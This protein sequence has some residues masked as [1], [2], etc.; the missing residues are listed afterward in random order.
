MELRAAI[1]STLAYFDLFDY[2]PTRAEVWRWLFAP[3]P[4]YKIQDTK[5]TIA[6][7]DSSIT[8]LVSAGT[9]KEE[10]GFVYLADR[11]GLPA[12]REERYRHS[13]RK[14]RRARRWARV[15]GA[16]PGVELVGIGNTLAFHAAKDASDIDFFIVTKPGTIW[17]TRALCAG[18]AALFRLRPTE[19]VTRDKLCLSFF[20]TD[21]A[22]DLAPLKHPGAELDIYLLYWIAQMTPL[23]G[24]SHAYDKFFE[25][26]AWVWK[27]LPNTAVRFVTYETNMTGRVL[28][29]LGRVLGFVSGDFMKEKQML[30]FPPAINEAVARRDGSAV[31]SDSM[32]K[33]HLNDRRAQIFE[34]WQQRLST[35]L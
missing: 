35:L 5:Y 16:L 26:N 29:V 9:L 34:R 19:T 32:L 31:I 18:L 21:D 22:L 4:K 23:A 7:V 28:G 33:F 17:R 1:I 13:V 12:L 30:K 25:A 2:P 8:E 6:D 11:T 20:V 24:S 10:N 27:F 3:D 14:W 15:F